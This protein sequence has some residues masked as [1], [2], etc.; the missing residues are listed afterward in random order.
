[1]VIAQPPDNRDKNQGE[2]QHD[3]RMVPPGPLV[4]GGRR[5]AGPQGGNRR[6]GIHPAAG[7]RGGGT[8]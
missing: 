3:R 4:W 6:A 7:D 5:V 8:L 2:P 1:M